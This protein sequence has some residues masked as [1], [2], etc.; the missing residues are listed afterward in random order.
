MA[1]QRFGGKVALVTGG[2]SGIGRASALLFA[3]QGA[4]VV[5]SDVAVEGGEET[6]SHI[7]EFGGKATFVEADVSDAAK[8]K[9]LIERTVEA[10]SRLDYAFNNAG[11]EGPMATN[12]ADYSD[13]DWDRVIGINLKGA[14]LCMKHEIPQMLE[15]GGG[16][17]VNN[18]SVAG[19]VG[20]EDISAY[21]AS[22]HGLVGLTKTAALEYAHSGI[23]VN[24][25]CPGVIRTPMIERATSGSEDAEAGFAALEPV[26]RMGTPEEVAEAVVWLCSEAA[27]F[28]TGHAMA[29]DG[30]LVAR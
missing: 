1:E 20:F 6:V 13:D 27:S 28:V 22:K 5:V 2:A 10:Y 24:T 9:T 23:R 30:G 21:V 29:V 17:I 12:T 25:V 16:S 8:V 14:W 7:E 15:Q 18:S 11:I 26:G 19:L 3:Q 4:S